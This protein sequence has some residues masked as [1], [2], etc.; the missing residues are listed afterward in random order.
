MRTSPKLYEIEIIKVFQGFERFLKGKSGLD[1]KDRK[2]LK[3]Y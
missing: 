1:R 3:I 2:H